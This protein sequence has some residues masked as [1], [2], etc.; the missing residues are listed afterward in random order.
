MAEAR[1]WTRQRLAAEGIAGDMAD[2][3]V[4][5]VSEVATNACVHTA[6][7]TPG[8]RF[9]LRVERTEWGVRVECE[10]QGAP[11]G[12]RLGYTMSDPCAIGGRGLALLAELADAYGDRT[13]ATGRTVYFELH[14]PPER[15]PRPP[16]QRG[17]P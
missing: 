12:T 9:R 4:L 3:A 5:L 10:D 13:T 6:S 15:S 16:V 14:R 8:G 11:I 17:A 7:G 1:H 2:T